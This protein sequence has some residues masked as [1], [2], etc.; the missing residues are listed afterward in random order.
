MTSNKHRAENELESP[1]EGDQPLETASPTQEE[2]PAQ[3]GESPAGGE[4]VSPDLVSLQNKLEETRLTAAEYLDG[5]Q[6][7]MAE[8]ANYKKRQEREREQMFQTAV[9]SVVKRYLEVVD[10]LERALKKRPPDGEGAAWA[11]GVELIYRKLLTALDAEGVKVMDALGQPFDPAR[12][13][14]IG[15][16]DSPDHQSGQIVE[17]IQQGYV[18]GERVLRPALVRIAM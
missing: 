17:I 1:Q 4:N 7:A 8:F 9:G 3:V 2:A 14:A 11:E 16:V 18:I 12:H 10:D 15:Q 6:R 5:W 13:E